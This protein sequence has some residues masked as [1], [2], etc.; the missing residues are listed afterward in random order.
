MQIANAILNQCISLCLYK[1]GHMTKA[2]KFIYHELQGDYSHS[3]TP[4]LIVNTKL[5]CCCHFR[6]ANMPR[7]KYQ[8]CV[9]K[10]QCK[11]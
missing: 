5:S 3:Q 10:A 11:S 9:M 7:L 4:L 8:Q 1:I 6:E 2:L